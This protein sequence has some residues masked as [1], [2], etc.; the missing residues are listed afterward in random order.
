MC[1]GLGSL[2]PTFPDARRGCLIKV[3]EEQWLLTCPQGVPNR[4]RGRESGSQ[5]GDGELRGVIICQMGEL[6][7]TVIPRES[8]YLWQDTRQRIIVAYLS[9]ISVCLCGC[10]PG[11]PHLTWEWENMQSRQDKLLSIHST[12]WHTFIH[13]FT[14]ALSRLNALSPKY[15][16]HA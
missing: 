13:Q 14:C 5:S 1:P 8:L 7:G 3:R 15:S 9:S 4:A 16:N 6:H 11:S 12:H 10:E 2:P